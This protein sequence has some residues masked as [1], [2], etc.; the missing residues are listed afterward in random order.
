MKHFKKNLIFACLASLLVVFS[1]CNKPDWDEPEISK[2]IINATNVIGASNNFVT[3]KALSYS[4]GHGSLVSIASAE[5]KN[6]GF[7]MTLPSPVPDRLFFSYTPFGFDHYIYDFISDM[8][9]RWGV[10]SYFMAY[11]N[12]GDEVAEIFCCCEEDDYGAI[13]CYMYADR[14]FTI[15][16]ETREYVYNCTLKKGWNTL[17]LIWSNSSDYEIVTTQKPMGKSFKWYAY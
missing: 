5:F 9:A 16:G 2:G 17:Y 12:D 8:N 15:E 3:V 10:I 13:V 14:N 7:T 11:D 6:G 4:L 1:N